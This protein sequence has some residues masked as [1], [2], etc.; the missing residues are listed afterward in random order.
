MSRKYRINSK[1]YDIKDRLK[2]KN[3]FCIS[4]EWIKWAKSYLNRVDRRNAKQRMGR[5]NENDG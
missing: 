3:I 2:H 5:E 1:E 4:R